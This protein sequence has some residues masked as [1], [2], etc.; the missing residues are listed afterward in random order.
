MKRE[1]AQR[2]PGE[3]AGRGAA[4]RE[5]IDGFETVEGLHDDAAL[6]RAAIAELPLAPAVHVLVIK[7]PVVWRE[8]RGILEFRVVPVF[9]DAEGGNH[10]SLQ[11]LR[12]PG[13]AMC[14]L[15][16]TRAAGVVGHAAHAHVFRA[17]DARIRIFPTERRGA[18]GW[19]A[20]R[21]VDGHALGVAHVDPI[22]RAEPLDW[23]ARAAGQIDH[24]WSPCI[25][26]K[27]RYERC[28]LS[29]YS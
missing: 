11:E 27:N 14:L 24:G 2:A 6:L 12:V 25:D 18:V 22:P 19:V 4:T 10:A 23:I 3:P 21:V 28:T 5:P 29:L 20:R 26:S 15:D 7:L 16:C 17:E 9:A 8:S 1:P 13:H